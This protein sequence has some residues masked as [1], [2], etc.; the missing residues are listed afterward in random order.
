MSSCKV[1]GGEPDRRKPDN[2]SQDSRQRILEAAARV[3]ARKG[4]Q[5][6]SLD[7]IAAEAA[8]TKGAIY[9]HFRSKNDLFSSLLKQRFQHNTAPMPEELVRVLAAT[10]VASRKRGIVAMLTGM[11]RRIREDADWPRLYLEFLSQSRAKDVAAPLRELAEH[12]RDIA[13]GMVQQMQAG[14]LARSD[15]DAD[16]LA[17]FWCALMDGYLLAWVMN[18]EGFEAENQM[19]QLVDMLWRGMSPGQ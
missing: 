14:G 2:A 4:F 5:R 18:P 9:W 17:A 7:E 12:G 8:L 6:A 1:F 16:M 10:D 11:I 3:F 19:E 15:L 13:R